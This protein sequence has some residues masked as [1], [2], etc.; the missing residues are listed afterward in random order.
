MY[1]PRKFHWFALC[2]DFVQST[3]YFTDIRPAQD[4]LI[5]KLFQYCEIPQNSQTLPSLPLFFIFGACHSHFRNLPITYFSLF[6]TLIHAPPLNI[7]Y[8]VN[9]NTQRHEW[10]KNGARG[11]YVNLSLGANSTSHSAQ[12]SKK[13][14]T[15]NAGKSEHGGISVLD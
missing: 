12:T 5:R 10:V 3:I 11:M 8:T 9:V 2:N 15:S 4:E 13:R 7:I 1:L 6:P 14:M